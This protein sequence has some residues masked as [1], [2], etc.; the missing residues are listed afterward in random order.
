MDIEE[1][2]A[3]YDADHRLVWANKQYTEFIG[4]GFD[5]IKGQ[6]H[7]EIWK[8]GDK[9]TEKPPIYKPMM[10]GVTHKK[11]ISPA[12]EPKF[13]SVLEIPVKDEKEEII[14]VIETGIDKTEIKEMEEKFRVLKEA[15]N[16]G[17][18]I[19]QDGELKFV[20]D[21]LL[22]I[23]GYSREEIKELRFFSLIHPEN[24][25]EIKEIK[26][27]AHENTPHDFQEKYQFRFLN[28]NDNYIWLQLNPTA[29][30]YNGKPAVLGN[31]KDISEMKKGGD[32]YQ[33]LIENLNEVMYVLDKKAQIK[34]ISPNVKEIAGYSD[35]E[36]TGKSY[37]ELVH[38]EDIERRFKYFMKALSGEA[39]PTDYRFITK[40]EE[41]RW[42]RTQARPATKNGEII[43][44]QGILT[45]ITDLKEAEKREQFLHSL[46]RHDV[47][48]KIQIIQGYNKLLEDLNLSEEAI[49]YISENKKAAEEASEIIEKVKMLVKAQKE[50]IK[51][52]KAKDS[53]NKAI[54]LS[55]SISEANGIKIE[56]Q[57]K[58]KVSK[59]LAGSLLDRVFYNIIENAIKHSDAT[60]IQVDFEKTDDEV[61]CI[62]E[63]NGRGIDNAEKE[64]VLEKGY[65]TDQVNGTGIGL[66]LVKT[67]LETY[68]GDLKVKDSELGGARF[69]VYLQ[70]A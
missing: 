38:P 65:T 33:S 64:K 22:Q 17:V 46:L 43:G 49:E 57:S 53:L 16:N 29:V 12:K 1:F 32:R 52:V 36:L 25:E 14:G 4:L 60:K 19:F 13:W 56:L 70:K 51:P 31:V 20:N 6:R 55:R 37:M 23:S 68:G 50:E 21:R 41:V 44:V 35:S 62:I 34:Y 59:V 69:D 27:K 24:R 10:T 28:A 18:F 5:D 9:Q 2:I 54:K 67:L 61:I 42:V 26:N 45:D 7:D 48:N 11:N 3:F 8:N 63:D 39:K 15:S 40:N 47:N 66:F 58:V 30:K